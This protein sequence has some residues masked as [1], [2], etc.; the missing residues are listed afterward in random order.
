MATLVS[1]KKLGKAIK[2]A[3]GEND[4]KKRAAMME[5]AEAK[6]AKLQK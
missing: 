4:P 5:K 1:F 2:K 3:R 6:R